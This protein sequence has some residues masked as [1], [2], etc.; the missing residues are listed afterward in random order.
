LLNAPG[1]LFEPRA[2]LNFKSTRHS[3]RSER[4]GY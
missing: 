3:T 4:M 2:A 1:K